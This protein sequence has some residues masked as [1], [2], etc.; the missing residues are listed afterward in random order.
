MGDGFD[1]EEWRGL[2]G[3]LGR[4]DEPLEQAAFS[5]RLRERNEELSERIRAGEF[6]DGDDGL[7]R[8]IWQT[9]VHKVEIASPRESP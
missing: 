5:A 4:E 1:R 8:H 6:D 9:V 7:V 3:L 2:D